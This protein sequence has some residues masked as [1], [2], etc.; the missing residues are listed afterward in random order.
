MRLSFQVEAELIQAA[1]FAYSVELAFT[2]CYVQAR[3]YWHLL[4]TKLGKF[5]N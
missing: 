1:A 4:E 5:T 3:Q 2:T